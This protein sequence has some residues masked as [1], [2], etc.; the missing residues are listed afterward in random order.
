VHLLITQTFTSNQLVLQFKPHI[1]NRT[2]N[3]STAF[4]WPPTF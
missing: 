3:V 4:S 2:G 1:N